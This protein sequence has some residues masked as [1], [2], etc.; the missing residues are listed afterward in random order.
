VRLCLV[1]LHLVAT[2]MQFSGHQDARARVSLCVLAANNANNDRQGRAARPC[3]CR[4]CQKGCSSRETPCRSVAAPVLAGDEYEFRYLV[5]WCCDLCVA[6]APEATPTMRWIKW[7][8][9]TI[10]NP[11]ILRIGTCQLTTQ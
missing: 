4:A 6:Q 8:L 11:R 2:K 1:S 3:L 7:R 5:G 9:S 10:S